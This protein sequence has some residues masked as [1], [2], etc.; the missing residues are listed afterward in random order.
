LP[1][2][3]SSPNSPRPPPTLDWQPCSGRRRLEP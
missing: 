1:P 3:T 2:A